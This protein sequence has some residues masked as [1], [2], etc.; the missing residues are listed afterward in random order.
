MNIYDIAEKAEVSIATVSRILNQKGNV[1]PKT[2]EKVLKVM[3]EMGYTP[4]AFARALGLDSIKMIGVVCSDVSDIY[5]AK[6]VSVIE[7]E[8]REQGYDAI[9]CCTGTDLK[10]KKKAIDVLLS[11]RVDALILIGSIFQEHTDNSHIEKAAMSIPVI[12]INGEYEFENTYSV[13]CDEYKAVKDCVVSLSNS[14]HKDVIYIY[15]S[16]SFSSI[17]KRK[18]F[19]S[20]IKSVGIPNG[21]DLIY[22][23]E[24]TLESVGQTIDEIIKSGVKFT[25]VIT[26]VDLLAV[27]AVKALARNGVK[28]PEE[29]SVVG[30]NNSVIAEYSSPTITSI[31][32]KVDIL[33]TDA[34]RTLLDVFEK[35]S[36]A[37]VKT[38][39]GELVI[40]ESCSHN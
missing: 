16:E 39:Q 24:R 32:N 31:D 2:K 20:G 36:V 17:N 33:C 29:V 28:V 18:G 9:L 6:A 11:K 5:Y 12:I 40:R 37:R 10:D 23:C 26:S 14:G 3:D 4:N 38:V 34:V 13:K 21:N 30:F 22:K 1:S 15:N 27:G 19:L 25:A 35:K 8:L 7:N